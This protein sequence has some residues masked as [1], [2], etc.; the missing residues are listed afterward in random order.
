MSAKCKVCYEKTQG[1]SANVHKDTVNKMWKSVLATPKFVVNKIKNT[2]SRK[3]P[4]VA[5]LF[6][7]CCKYIQAGYIDTEGLPVQLHLCR[8]CR[9]LD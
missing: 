4:V 5:K 3:F 1:E 8:K 9:K 6:D 7:K 2:G